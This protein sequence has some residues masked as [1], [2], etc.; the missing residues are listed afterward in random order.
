MA[1]DTQRPT[2]GGDAGVSDVDAGRRGFIQ[3]A[4]ATGAARAASA[5]PRSRM[6]RPG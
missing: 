6:R 2:D 1:N 5:P 3:G 4:L